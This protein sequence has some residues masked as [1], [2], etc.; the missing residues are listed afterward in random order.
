MDQ[1]ISS[2]CTHVYLVPVSLEEK[3]PLFGGMRPPLEILPFWK[4][5][6]KVQ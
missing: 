6:H 5:A 3:N 4:P 2:T 1:P